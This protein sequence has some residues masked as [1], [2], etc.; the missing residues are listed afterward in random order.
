[1]IKSNKILT[2]LDKL[3]KNPTISTVLFQTSILITKKK[4]FVAEKTQKFS[5]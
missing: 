5:I 4:I 1:M 2:L 3:T